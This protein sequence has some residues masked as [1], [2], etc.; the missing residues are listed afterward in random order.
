M[1]N[2]RI[3]PRI[4]PIVVVPQT[5]LTPKTKEVVADEERGGAWV[6][7][8]PRQVIRNWVNGSTSGNVC[9]AVSISH[10][11]YPDPVLI[12]ATSPPYG[13]SRSLEVVNKRQST[14]PGLGGNNQ[15]LDVIVYRKNFSKVINHKLSDGS[16]GWLYLR[17]RMNFDNYPVQTQAP[18]FM[19]LGLLAINTLN[20]SNG[21]QPKTSPFSI[22]HL[23]W[24]N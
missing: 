5:L 12:V 17:F 9:N 2:P 11:P 6:N 13:L 8:T 18:Q 19:N 15:K 3:D 22:C 16:R 10:A 24:V 20:E 14:S 4:V 7:R 23:I 1:M 21:V